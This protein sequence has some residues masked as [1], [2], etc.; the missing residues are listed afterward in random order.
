MRFYKVMMATQRIFGNVA[1]A[2]VFVLVIVCGVAAATAKHNYLLYVG[3][4]TGS[5]YRYTIGSGSSKT[6][7]RTSAATPMISTASPPC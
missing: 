7:G 4:Y 6:R 5:I 2:L 1:A 3:T